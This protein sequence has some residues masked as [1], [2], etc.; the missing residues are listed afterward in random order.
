MA[1]I[2]YTTSTDSTQ[3]SPNYIGLQPVTTPPESSFVVDTFTGTGVQTVFTLS[4]PKPPSVRSLLVSVN[5][6]L[7][8]P[9]TDYTLTGQGNLQFTTAPANGHTISVHHLLFPRNE[10]QSTI[11]KLDDISAGFD[12][13]TTVFTLQAGGVAANLL[14]SNVLIVSI[15][16]VIQEPG[17]AYTLSGDAIT[18]T[19]APAAIS[20]FYAI[21]I[22]TVA[23]G[24][25]ADGTIT[26][27]KFIVDNSPSTGKVLTYNSSG[28][29]TWSTGLTVTNG[30]VT[31]DIGFNEK[32]AAKT[33][34]TGVV[35]HDC[36]TGHIFYHS[37]LSN[38][39]TPNFTNLSLTSG[40]ATAITMVLVQGATAYVPNAV[41]IG[42]ASVT[43]NWQG[44]SSAPSGNAN[45]TDIVNFSIL[46][47]SGTYTVLGQLTSFG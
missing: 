24:T 38:N 17:V 9:T 14:G 39:F 41:Q 37:S 12:G 21:D 15:D 18:F 32:F 1:Y 47:N 2:G 3:L 28:G 23:I 44:S 7:T 11:R 29:L 33:S 19:E 4:S 40:Y 25:P 10:A 45:K 8:I 22:G 16:G 46:N 5:G 26:P 6:V 35:E 43:V 13:A 36:S 27:A 30:L 31:A 34:A 20:D 42:G